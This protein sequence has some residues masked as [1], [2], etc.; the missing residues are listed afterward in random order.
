MKRH[1]SN[2]SGIIARTIILIVS[3]SAWSSA[4]ASQCLSGVVESIVI[5][6][7]SGG[8]IFDSGNGLRVILKDNHSLDAARTSNM[9][10]TMGYAFLRLLLYSNSTGYPVSLHDSKGKCGSFDGVMLA[11]QWTS[12]VPKSNRRAE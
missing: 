4:P 12:G 10:D 8:Q 1:I 5:G 6:Y 11:A 7:T 9:N 3:A 2:T